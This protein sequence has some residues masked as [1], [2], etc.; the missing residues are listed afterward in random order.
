MKRKPI[1][2]TAVVAVVVFLL[3]T[4]AQVQAA[5]FVYV[6]NIDG[7]NLSQYDAAGGLLAPL[8]PPTVSTQ[9]NPT[10]IAVSPGGT[11][12]YVTIAEPATVLQFSVG[13]N[14]GLT[15]ESTAPV[16]PGLSRLRWRSAQ[17]VR[18]STSATRE[19]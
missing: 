5:P 4:A 17:T 6:T 10:G 9:N 7:P 3:G 12:V 15:L 14:G 19:A 8:S 16:P 11:S 1:L 18:T 2:T 13:A